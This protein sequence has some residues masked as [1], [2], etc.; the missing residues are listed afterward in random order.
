MTYV[1][2][3]SVTAIGVIF[4]VLALLSML[5]RYHGWRIGSRH[6]EIDDILII[7]AAVSS[8]KNPNKFTL[9]ANVFVQ[10]L[11]IIAGVGMIIGGQL[12]IVGG[13]SLPAITP[14]QYEHLGK[15]EYAFWIC[16]VL[17]IGFIKLSILFLFRRF[18]RGR[19]FRTL[20]DIVNWTLITCVTLWTLVFL[21][22]EI[23]ACGSNPY[24]SWSSLQ[25]LRGA[26]VDT[27]AM[28]TGCAVFSWVMDLA[29]LIEPLFKIG[30]LSMSVQRKVQ[31]SLVFLFSILAVVAGLLR[32]IIWIQIE[33]QGTNGP[34]TTVL[35][36]K[37]ITT[38]LTG[39]VSVILF[40]TYI[41]IGI[42]FLVACLPPC[43]GI[44]DKLV[45]K[46]V[47]RL[48]SFSSSRMFNGSKQKELSNGSD[49]QRNAP[50][51]Q[52]DFPKTQSHG[53]SGQSSE[54]TG[55]REEF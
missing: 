29:I 33:I 39:I 35:G 24:L 2:K 54:M 9:V 32:M 16:H 12:D 22:F 27:F 40:W 36:D 25:S 44:L 50:W 11:T 4:P 43:A 18:F 38:D 46:S 13:H 17:A 6:L 55:Y 23:F 42:G 51:T 28:Q 34:V 26:C 37:F 8:N 10:F 47:Y 5:I 41:E 14:I 52:A 1:N 53:R 3:G 48:R 30:S 19:A 21:F 31:A 15:F 7:P 45:H 20:F 49:S